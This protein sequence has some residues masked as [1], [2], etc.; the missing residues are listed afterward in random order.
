MDAEEEMEDIQLRNPFHQLPKDV[1]TNILA[2]LPVVSLVQCRVVCKSW[3]EAVSWP[4]LLQAR[5]ESLRAGEREGM[6]LL[7]GRPRRTFSLAWCAY[8]PASDRWYWLPLPRW[9]PPESTSRRRCAS[10]DGA[11][12]LSTMCRQQHQHL[13][14]RQQQ[15]QLLE[16]QQHQLQRQQHQQLQGQQH[17]MQQLK[18]EL[19]R[20]KHMQQLA[21][22]RQQQESLR[23]REQM[24]QMRQ[25]DQPQR[26]LVQQQEDPES[27]TVICIPH[28]G[29]RKPV[30]EESEPTIC[31]PHMGNPVM[32]S[33][34]SL[35]EFPRDLSLWD[36]RGVLVDAKARC[37]KVVA[38]K[39]TE[40]D[41]KNMNLD[42][43]VVPTFVFDSA[44]GSWSITSCVSPLASLTYFQNNPNAGVFVG[45]VLY[46]FTSD[47][48]LVTYNLERSS[49]S[50][51]AV[52][53]PDRYP[54]F[55]IFCCMPINVRDRLLCVVMGMADAVVEDPCL[56][57]WELDLARMT[58]TVVDAM[59]ASM[60]NHFWRSYRRG[61]SWEMKSMYVFSGQSGWLKVAGGQDQVYIMQ[62]G[63]DFPPYC[64]VALDLRQ[65]P[66]AWRWLPASPYD[67]FYE[68]SLHYLDP[69]LQ[70]GSWN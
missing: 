24:Q 66:G 33:W 34:A 42:D 60:F 6:L 36:V 11:V 61:Q 69:W 52:A 53:K 23:M 58:W 64:V 29:L 51:L 26:H 37:F 41:S 48:D 9:A 46:C 8:D 12:L 54:L 3:N 31:I 22:Q 27:E 47:W 35:P 44:L 62:A 50:C 68:R 45:A 17:Q 16:R 63:E 7:A 4:G 56:H 14:Q 10:A 5:L 21:Q 28:M 38:V 70:F 13:V 1:V 65:T 57:I 55:R 49:W 19:L 67:W 15:E 40:S 30:Q 2:R 18:R 32:G 39:G 43:P 25:Q 59:P 20:Q